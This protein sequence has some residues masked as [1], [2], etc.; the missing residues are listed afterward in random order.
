M[1][2]WPADLPSLTADGIRGQIAIGNSLM[3]QP[4]STG[5]TRSNF[6]EEAGTPPTAPIRRGR[7]FR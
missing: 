3:G 2:S 5:T 1:S 6:D 4:T 7:Y